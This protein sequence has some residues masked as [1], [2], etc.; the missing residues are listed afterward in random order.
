MV[1][2]LLE[3]FEKIN[4][5]QAVW[6]E[7]NGGKALCAGGDVK[8]L[9]RPNNTAEDRSRFFR[10]EFYLDY[11]FTELKGHMISCWD[12]IIMGGGV[13]LTAFGSFV[14]AT[15]K[16]VFAMPEAKLGFFT[17]VGVNYLFA[18]MRGNLGYYL[19]MTGMR[20]KGEEAYIAGLANYYIPSS[21][22]PKVKSEIKNL[23]SN[24]DKI[25][26]E[27]QIIASILSKYHSPSG[28]K[29]LDN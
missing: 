13:G 3:N 2:S 25:I 4:S 28:K 16:T 14:I 20:L 7:G 1:Y 15:E 29:H 17:D 23:F 8:I 6:V 22:L 24:K 9:Y 5:Y 10:N 11:K 21:K 27:K 12:G 18:R 19:G 26:N